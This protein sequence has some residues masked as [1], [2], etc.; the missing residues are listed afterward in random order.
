V[1]LLW[2]VLP[3]VAGTAALAG[4]IGTKARDLPAVRSYWWWLPL[5][6]VWTGDAA[7]GEARPLLE[8]AGKGAAA[9]LLWSSVAV[10][11]LRRRAAKEPTSGTQVQ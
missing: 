8:R 2:L 9:L 4:A 3:L 1:D 5:L 7:L 11:L 10:V 6:V